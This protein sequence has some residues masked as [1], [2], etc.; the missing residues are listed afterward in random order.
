MQSLTGLVLF[1]SDVLQIC[2][3]FGIGFIVISYFTDMQSLTGLVLFSSD[4]LQICNPWRDWL[5]MTLFFLI[6]QHPTN[7]HNYHKRQSKRH[8]P[9]GNYF[10]QESYILPYNR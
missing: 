8:K 4:V 2:N 7:Y 1:S 10:V 9:D 3:P 5:F 6:I